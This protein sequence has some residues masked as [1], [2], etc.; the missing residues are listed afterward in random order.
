MPHV[1]A[2]VMYGQ[3]QGLR[4]SLV[5]VRDR[6]SG[7]PAPRPCRWQKS[8]AQRLKDEYRRL[9]G[10]GDQPFELTARAWVV[11]AASR[12]RQGE[13]NDVGTR[14]RRKAQR[15]AEAHDGAP[16]RKWGPYLSERQWGTVREDYSNDGN[17]WGYFSHDQ[18]R[19]R[20]YRWGEDGLAGVSD[21]RQQLCFAVALWNG[22][23]PIL[24]ERLFGLTNS[25]GNHGEDVKEYYFY[26][27]STPTHSYMK[28]LYK[29]PQA[30]FPYDE[31]IEKNRARTRNDLE[32][33]L[34]E[35]GVF[36]EDRY[37]DVFVEYA[38]AAPDDLLIRITAINRGPERA[39]LHVLPSLWFR[40]TWWL[41]GD[42]VVPSLSAAGTEVA[43]SIA[44]SHP[45]LGDSILALEGL[46]ELLFTN[47][48]TNTERIA[49]E[50]NSH[51]VRQG[52]H[53]RRGG[54][55]SSRGG[56][57]GADRAPRPRPTI[58][59]S[60]S[61]VNH[62]PSGCASRRTTRRSAR[63]ST[64][65]SRRGKNEADEFYAAV[66]PD[67]L[68]ADQANVMR[69]ALAGMMWSKQYYL[70]DVDRWLDERG[71][72]PFD[73]QSQRVAQQQLAP[74]VQRRRHLDARQVGV[75]LVRGMGP[76]LSRHL[77]DAGRRRLRQAAAGAVATRSVP[78]SQRPAAGLRM[79]L[80]RREPAC[81]RLVD[82]LHLSAAEGA[83]RWRRQTSNGSSGS[84]SGCCSTSPGGSIARTAPA[85]T[86]S[87]AAS[88][89]ST[90][91]ASSTAARLC[92]RAATWSRLT[93]PRGWRCSA[94]T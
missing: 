1:N 49:G 61:P 79:E 33:E 48:E 21:D 27:D 81:S 11:P 68:N 46:P 19:S 91:S 34:L 5:R 55:R 14:Q 13:R 36:D 58:G 2:A 17:A 93:A 67:S 62:D 90:T 6:V 41:D 73:P 23:D 30:P 57:P 72:N 66:T 40:N 69:Q 47:N 77:A 43:R 37:F 22:R 75:P 3:L 94:R 80:Q 12:D 65:Y 26:L 45:V 54:R 86:C 10:V 51:A 39:E 18:A 85:T 59:R 89:V 35:T 32:Y 92:R 8:S 24:K 20:A 74:H 87:K 71:A 63:T 76:G 83:Q 29:Y 31:L 9:L 78:A 52:R 84:S 64:R 28:Y 4:R 60:W 56:R 25:E 50:P 15:L 53:Q 16:W 42:E 7:L 44:V 70:F 38:K 82:D 88:W